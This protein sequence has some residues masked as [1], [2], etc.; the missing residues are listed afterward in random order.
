MKTKLLAPVL[1]A[2]L[3]CSVAAVPADAAPD[4][5]EV[6][7]RLDSLVRD[8]KFPAALAAVQAKGR[9]T[10]YTAGTGEL[11][12]QTP[13]PRDGKVRAGSNTK[14]FVAVVVLQLVA[15]GKVELDVPIERYLPGLVRG[16]GID[17]RTITVR[18]LL[19]H[20]SGLPNYTAYIGLEKFEDIQHRYV[21]PRELLDRA[22]EHPADFAPGTKW[23]YSNTN[24][25]L[26]GLL[27][28]HVT[29]R[30]V[31]EQ[32]TERVIDRIGLRDT[33]WPEV[34]DQDIDGRHPHGYA[35]ADNAS[36]RVIDA[37]ELDPSWGWAAGALIS[38]PSDLNKFFSALLGGRLLDAARL[39]EMRKTVEAEIWPGARY[40]LG[41][42]STPLTCGGEY[43][44]H[45]G[46]IHGFETRGGVTEDGRA[47][48]VA[49]TA[50][51]GT[52]DRENAQRAAQAVL[53]TVDA[54]LCASR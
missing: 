2:A 8:E 21:Q 3:A 40:G 14:T 6:Q 16:E 46:D 5:T 23:E 10:S 9:S 38:T 31:A 20:T 42:V 18:Q 51:P 33:Y 11:G 52:F 41:L 26:A 28:E 24:Y 13:V 7:R 19:Q 37:T 30:P 34:G 32:V 35:V 4:R 44:G 45:G 43:W 48:E 22:L 25:L 15:E 12:K 17:G 27:I 1:A 36:D 54:A 47:T 50:T 39:A 49:V 53:S 29:G